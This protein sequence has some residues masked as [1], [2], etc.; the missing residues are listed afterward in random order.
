MNYLQAVNKV[1][2]R[3]RENTVNSVDETLYSRLVGEFVND[4]NRMVEDSWDWSDLRTV[5]TVT[6]VAGHHNY[7]I[8]DVSS[9]FK[10]LNVTNSTQLCFVNLG[11]ETALQQNLYINPAPLSVPA[12]YLYTGFNNVNNGVDFSLYPSP[13]K[14]YTLRFNIVDRTEELTSDT[15][16]LKA[17]YLPVVQFA[18]AMAVEERGETG[19][20]SAAML[21]GIAK[22]S[23][24][25]AISFDAARF[26]TETIWVDV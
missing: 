3:L 11:T 16:G 20:T 24:S 10:T 6:T 19:G 25:D 22:S 23:L 17:P 15:Q 18:H 21:T 13:D 5:K 14:A 12:N 26:P 8:P 9:A 2:R 1:L 4:A 7:S